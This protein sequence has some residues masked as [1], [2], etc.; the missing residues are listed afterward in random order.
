[1][2]KYVSTH[3]N[4]SPL[5][6]NA[7]NVRVVLCS[8]PGIFA[9]IVIKE[10]QDSSVLK[11][12]GLVHSQRIFSARE[13]W[14]GSAFRMMRTSGIGYSILQ[15]MQ[16][17]VYLFCRKLKR[18]NQID[19][20]L[21]LLQTKDINTDSGLNF[22]KELKPDII[23]LANFNQKVS[24][25]V[26]SIPVISCL[27]IHPSLL[28]R[29]K[30]VDPVFSALY[31]KEQVLGV[32]IHKVDETFDTGAIL[33]Q[34]PMIVEKDRSVFYHQARLFQQGAKLAVDVI[35]QLTVGNAEFRENAAGHYDSWPTKAKINE[36]NNNGGQLIRY[37]EF[38]AM[39]K[40]TLSKP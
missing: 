6:A 12:V 25:S 2:K 18:Q 39:V 29:Y 19:G 14:I 24:V 22:L 40:E 9:D 34:A 20:Q 27:N 23:V 1:M 32:T 21:P 33:S 31:A 13:T 5:Q 35:K 15:F 10:L 36:F 3:A 16:T 4:P 26:I 11:L 28:P 7:E 30:G 8:Y 17:D 38:L 37:A